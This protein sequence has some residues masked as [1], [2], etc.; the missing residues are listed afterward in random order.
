MKIQLTLDNYTPEELKGVKRFLRDISESIDEYQKNE[1]IADDAAAFRNYVN[2][3]NARL[4][5]SNTPGRYILKK[6]S[7]ISKNE[8][9]SCPQYAKDIRKDLHDKN[10]INDEGKLLVD[11]EFKASKSTAAAVIYGYSI[12]GTRLIS[13]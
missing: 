2:L 6:D 13:F 10:I 9:D 11:Y 5:Q 12:N 8:K 1:N 7:Y 3:K 4:E